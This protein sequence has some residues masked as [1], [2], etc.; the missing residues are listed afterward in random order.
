MTHQ[1]LTSAYAVLGL[2]MGV[3]KWRVRQRYKTLVR[4]WHPDRFVGDRQG[5]EEAT[6]QMQAINAA[7]GMIC[8]RSEIGE[9]VPPSH[10]A[11]EGRSRS[12]TR[13]E[14]QEIVDG[15][16]ETLRPP[17][18]LT[19]SQILSGALTAGAALT[20][21]MT[22]DGSAAIGIWVIVALP[23]ACIWFPAGIGVFDNH[24][25]LLS[26]M[27]RIVGWVVLILLLSLAV[28]QP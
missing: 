17:V 20:R 13:R 18:R 7:Y 25:P 11:D 12:W 5:V 28:L 1:E 9:T 21:W 22:H 14:I 24:N 8:S 6:R 2:S 4:R 23:L 16:N 27:V 3:S 26:G 15:I 19:A 10:P